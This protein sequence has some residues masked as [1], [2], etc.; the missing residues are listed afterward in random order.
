MEELLKRL[1][2]AAESDKSTQWYDVV[3]DEHIAYF[4][5]ITELELPG[6]LCRCYRVI[7]N[8]GFGPGYHLAGLPGGCE[9]A[10][11]DLAESVNELRIHDD[12]EASFLPLLNWGCNQVS[13]LDCDDSSVVTFLEGDFH[14]EEY[15]FETL[16]IKWCDGE[17]PDFETGGFRREQ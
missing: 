14:F 5:G 10:W 17:V 8:G 7:G 11:G 1:R 12:C 4:E 15:T 3:T 13:C 2:V 9:A 16:L 6:W